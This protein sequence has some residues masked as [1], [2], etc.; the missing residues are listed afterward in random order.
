MKIISLI[1]V[2]VLALTACGEDKTNS[3]PQISARWYTQSQV[4]MGHA[5]FTRHCS[6][7]HGEN[8]QG[9]P[10]WKKALPDASEPPPALNGTAHAWHHPLRILKRTIDMGGIPLGGKMPPFKDKLNDAEKEAAIAYFQSFWNDK[11]YNAWLGRGG[12]EK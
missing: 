2:I 3:A 11:I 9:N 10:D 7:C 4:D 1:G 8:A 5:V 6:G 12:Y